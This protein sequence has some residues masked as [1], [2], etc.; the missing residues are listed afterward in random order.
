MVLVGQVKV[1]LHV[2]VY[3]WLYN[4]LVAQRMKFVQ[5]KGMVSLSLSNMGPYRDRA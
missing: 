3:E 2:K 1:S 4:K 5:G